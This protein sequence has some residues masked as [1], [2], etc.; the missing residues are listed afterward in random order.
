MDIQLFYC[1]QR[2]KET[3]GT[4][5]QDHISWFHLVIRVEDTNSLDSR[6]KDDEGDLES[7]VVLQTNL[8]HDFLGSIQNMVTTRMEWEMEWKQ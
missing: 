4:S 6:R 3:L 1:L 7:K 8:V 2:R 5:F